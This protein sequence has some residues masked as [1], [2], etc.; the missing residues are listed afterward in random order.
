M[1]P[2]MKQEWHHLLFAHWPVDAAL[3]NSLL[4]PGMKAQ[5]AEGTAWISVVPFS[6]RNI[7]FV[8]TPAIPGA[9]ALL[10]LNVRTYV[11]VGSVS[12][13]YFFSLDAN[14]RL[15]VW[16]AKRFFYLNYRNASM[17]MEPAEDGFRF[18]SQ[19]LSL[20]ESKG[21]F[22][23][24]YVPKNDQKPSEMDGLANWLTNRD[25]LLTS[26]VQGEIFEGRVF[27][28]KWELT[29]ATLSIE[30]M[31]VD[32]GHGIEIKNKPALIQY[33][34]KVQVI[35]TG[36]RRLILSTDRFY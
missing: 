24:Q 3:I 33:A 27:H 35:T 1:K 20:N 30:V 17:V 25:T 16:F 2:L 5:I 36:I 12:G 22:Q 28:P 19:V 29:D 7:R 9:S 23:A 21:A 31:T 18:R 4:P 15:A 6:M 8:G 14:H 34:E 11:Q 32:V 10:E 26:T 13:V